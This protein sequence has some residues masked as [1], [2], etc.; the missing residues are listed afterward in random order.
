MDRKKPDHPYT[1]PP[2]ILYMGLI[3]ISLR[4]RYVPNE[5]TN[6]MLA[7]NQAKVIWVGT[8]NLINRTGVNISPKNEATVG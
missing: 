2:R 7:N 1:S 4:N 6:V 5:P 3:P 8:N